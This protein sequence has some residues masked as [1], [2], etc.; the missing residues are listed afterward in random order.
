[1]EPQWTSFGEYLEFLV[2]NGVS[3]NVAS[4]MGTTTARVNVLGKDNVAPTDKQLVQMQDVVRQAMKEGAIGVASSLIYTP[5]G[6]ASTE[7]LIAL[8]KAA[9]EYGGLYASHMRNEGRG[10][11]TALDELIRIAREAEIPAFQKEVSSMQLFKYFSKHT[12]VTVVAALL[13]FSLLGLSPHAQAQDPNGF[14]CSAFPCMNGGTC[15]TVEGG[16]YC[17]CAPGYTGSIC[18]LAETCAENEFVFANSCYA[19]AAGTTNAAGDEVGGPD[20]SCDITYCAENESVTSN[21][22]AAG[23]SNEAGDD[24]SGSDT[25]CDTITCDVPVSVPENFEAGTCILG[26]TLDYG[27]NC[28]LSCADGFIPVGDLTLSCDGGPFGE[29]TGDCLPPIILQDGFE[30]VD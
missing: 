8:S 10:I 23:T 24:A 21:A 9:K 25:F 28:S 30:A 22:C 5:G 20:T 6:F 1:M 26:S 16:W 14:G 4:F 17:N 29:P 13:L 19:C 2:E 15:I 27:Q 7:E 12:L 11:F 3:P 18:D